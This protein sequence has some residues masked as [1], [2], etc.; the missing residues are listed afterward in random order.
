MSEIAERI[1]RALEKVRNATT[2]RE[3]VEARMEIVK[4]IEDAEKAKAVSRKEPS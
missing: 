4:A 1:D 2:K 3:V